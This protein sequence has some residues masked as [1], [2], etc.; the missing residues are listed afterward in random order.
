MS[1]DSRIPNPNK[2]AILGQIPFYKTTFIAIAQQSNPKTDMFLNFL[3][4]VIVDDDSGD[5]GEC[6]CVYVEMVW[7]QFRENNILI[8]G[9]FLI[10]SPVRKY[11]QK[12]KKESLLFRPHSCLIHGV[13]ADDI[14]LM[15]DY[16]D[17][18]GILCRNNNLS[19]VSFH[20][21][22]EGGGP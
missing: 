7:K 4:M 20:G 18:P 11:F 22:S 12:C 10:V 2:D 8:V 16:S 19:R 9:I 6:R 3:G 5:D 21:G 14:L 13:C 1:L 15:S 17:N